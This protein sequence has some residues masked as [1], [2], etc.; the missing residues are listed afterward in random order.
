MGNLLI[1][2]DKTGFNNYLLKLI[3]NNVIFSN[4][5]KVILCMIL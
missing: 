1:G 4:A 2:I 5:L 3:S